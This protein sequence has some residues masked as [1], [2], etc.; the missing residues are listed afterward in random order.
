MFEQKVSTMLKLL[1]ADLNCE[2]EV[3]HRLTSFGFCHG[4]VARVLRSVE[5]L[6]CAKRPAHGREDN[7][8]RPLLLH[9]SHGLLAL[10]LA[11]EIPS[12]AIILIRASQVK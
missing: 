3:G 1:F 7:E 5:R 8:Q 9:K 6:P 11:A 4:L 2:L 12:S 10:I